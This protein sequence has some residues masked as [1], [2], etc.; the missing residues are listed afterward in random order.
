MT[1]K[2]YVIVLVSVTIFTLFVIA[3]VNYIIDPDNLY[4]SNK[5][6]TFSKNYVQKL[7]SSTNGLLL[8]QADINFR[9]IKSEMADQLRGGYDCAILGSSHVLQVGLNST[10][11]NG[12]NSTCKSIVN[13]SVPST[14]IE[15]FLSLLL[16]LSNNDNAPKTIVLNIDPWSLNLS[17]NSRWMV[18]KNDFIE[19]RNILNINH[20]YDTQ[21]ENSIVDYI[22][23]LFNYYYFIH[24]IKKI[25]SRPY[26]SE[27]PVFN[28]EDG[29]DTAVLLPNGSLLYSNE[30]INNHR[31]IH[32]PVP[33]S[34]RMREGKLDIGKTTM[35]GRLRVN[36]LGMYYSMDAINVISILVNYMK[37]NGFS[38]VFM[39]TPHHHNILKNPNSRSALAISQVEPIIRSLGDKLGVNVL[40]SFN[41]N[42]VGCTDDQFYDDTHAKPLCLNRILN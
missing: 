40:G 22:S 12:N 14:T 18:N 34:I 9:E 35:I 28:Y 11:E 6:S 10:K 27:A 39:M 13:L 29:Y 4:R 41:P 23:N 21:D 33:P 25:G 19:M 20:L 3:T 16:V 15:D 24:S 26:M 37:K 8:P 1:S 32:V 7:L 17:M 36:E 42:T 2:A 30:Y 5:A 38:I 31:N